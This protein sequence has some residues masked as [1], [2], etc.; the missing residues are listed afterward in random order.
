M[1]KVEYY[2][3]NLYNK[4]NWA[5][6]ISINKLDKENVDIIKKEFKEL[7]MLTQDNLKG[8]TSQINL[9]EISYIEYKKETND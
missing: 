3:V 7:G 8:F 4:Y 5:Q 6:F 1:D 9:R 2:T